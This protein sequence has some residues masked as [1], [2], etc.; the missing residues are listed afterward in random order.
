[1]IRVL[2]ITSMLSKFCKAQ[3]EEEIAIQSE[4]DVGNQTE[5]VN[6]D[7]QSYTLAEAQPAIS[8]SIEADFND[9]EGQNTLVY[10]NSDFF[11]ITQSSSTSDSG[12]DS[13]PLFL[14]TP[15]ALEF[16]TLS[17]WKYDSNFEI[18]PAD[19]NDNI[20]HISQ[21]EESSNDNQ[22]LTIRKDPTQLLNEMQ[23]YVLQA[24][25]LVEGCPNVTIVKTVN[26]KINMVCGDYYFVESNSQGEAVIIN[27]QFS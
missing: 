11:N 6:I 3:T 16:T 5:S 21:D 7:C 2:L 23:A 14:V 20:V 19:Q 18:Q 10:T 1:M 17:L 9:L 22:Q 26:I 25:M 12:E 24:Q 27:K 13:F 15:N 4:Q 8:W